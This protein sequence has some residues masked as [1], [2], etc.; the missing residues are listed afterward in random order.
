M[1]GTVVM[2]VIFMDIKG[3]PSQVYSPKGTNPGK[4]KFVH[5]GVCRN[6]AEDM[7]HIG[8]PVTFVTMSDETPMGRDAVARLTQEGVDLSCC[9]TAAEGGVG[10]WLAVMDENGD[11]AGSTSQMPDTRLLA[12]LIHE[13]GAEIVSSCRNVALE[14]D[15]GEAVSEEVVALTQRYGK[16]LYCVPANMSV[17]LRRPDLLT[18]T[19]C[20]ICNHIEAGK[21]FH[22]ALPEGSPDEILAA[23]REEGSRM[24]LRSMVVTLGESGSVY[25]DE[26]TKESGYCPVYPVRMVDSTG[27]G[28]AFF[29]GTVSGL[30]RGLPLERA[31]AAGTRLAALTI[32]S[33]EACCPQISDLWSFLQLPC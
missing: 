20:F 2:G 23:V 4:V 31:V 32:Q 1:L 30:T 9:A 19:R 7:A 24:H 5:G 16:D 14:M 11:L 13:R 18:H 6:V 28:D 27:A 22:R 12:Q 26:Q 33:A 17:I 10:L 15:I 29:A 3:F 25:Y 8:M 21:L